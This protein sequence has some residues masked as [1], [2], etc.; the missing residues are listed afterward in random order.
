ML[1]YRVQSAKWEI[2]CGWLRCAH[3]RLRVTV[4]LPRGRRGAFVCT[5]FVELLGSLKV[6]S[7]FLS[8]GFRVRETQTTDHP[9]DLMTDET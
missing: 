5:L 7:P 4:G 2:R 6:G 3:L 9:R 1:A 8:C